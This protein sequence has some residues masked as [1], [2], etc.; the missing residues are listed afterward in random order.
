MFLLNFI[1]SRKKQCSFD[2]QDVL[3]VSFCL[4]CFALLAL[5]GADC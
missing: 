1:L 3:F 2:I 5:K 4:E